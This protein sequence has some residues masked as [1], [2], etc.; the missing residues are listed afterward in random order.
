MPSKRAATE[1]QQQRGQQCQ[2]LGALREQGAFPLGVLEQ[3]D[4]QLGGNTPTL[5]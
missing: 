4:R 5:E 2:A 1:K 3:A